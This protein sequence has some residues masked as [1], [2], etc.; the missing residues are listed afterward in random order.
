MWGEMMSQ[1]FIMEVESVGQHNESVA[2]VHLDNSSDLIH[3][4]SSEGLLVSSL[5]MSM[6]TSKIFNCAGLFGRCVIFSFA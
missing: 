3:I 4:G 2:G 6:W 1:C 5:Y